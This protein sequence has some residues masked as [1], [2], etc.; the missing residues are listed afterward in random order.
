LYEEGVY[1]V[2]IASDRIGREMI[3]PSQKRR[4]TPK[5]WGSPCKKT[6]GISTWKGRSQRIAEWGGGS[7]LGGT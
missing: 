3:E 6:E 7:T 5:A 4:G 2:P 1:R